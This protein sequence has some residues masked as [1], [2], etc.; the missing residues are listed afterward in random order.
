MKKKSPFKVINLEN[1]KIEKTL[2]LSS[3]VCFCLLLLIQMLMINPSA[4]NILTQEE[5][6]EGVFLNNSNVLMNKETILIELE[7]ESKMDSL[8]VMINGERTARFSGKNIT[9]PVS[10]GELIEI[11][12]TG[13]NKMAK[14][15]IKSRSDDVILVI[16]NSTLEV[17]GNIGVLAR[18]KIKRGI[19]D[20]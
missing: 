9:L 18:I 6:V 10:D 20:F 7:N 11:D 19:L 1:K 12:G 2:V 13:T 17:N 15:N 14:V 8:W 4:R 5:K 3:I 16:D